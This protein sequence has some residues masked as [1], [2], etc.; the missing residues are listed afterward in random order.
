MNI[1]KTTGH[2]YLIV[3]SADRF[4]FPRYRS[5]LNNALWSDSVVLTHPRQL[6]TLEKAWIEQLY[7]KK[8]IAI[9]REKISG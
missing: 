5:N 4:C 3:K 8:V 9:N 1:Y 2:G 6:H 7:I